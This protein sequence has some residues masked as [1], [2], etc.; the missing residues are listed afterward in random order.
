MYAQKAYREIYSLTTSPTFLFANDPKLRQQEFYRNYFYI[1]GFNRLIKH[2]RIP[3]D[4]LIEAFTYMEEAIEQYLKTYYQNKNFIL[5]LKADAL[6]PAF[7]VT[8][9]SYYEDEEIKEND[10]LP[11]LVNWYKEKDCFYGLEIIEE[12]IGE[13]HEE[14]EDEDE[15]PTTAK[16]Y[17][18]IIRT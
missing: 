15:L 17:T 2:N 16:V 9:V 3:S 18:K 11:E 12:E 6:I 13:E 8:V 10:S 4:K 5:Y 7:T 14:A 1:H